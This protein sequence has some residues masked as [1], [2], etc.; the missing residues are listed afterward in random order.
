MT[1]RLVHP[2]LRRALAGVAFFAALVSARR[3]SAEDCPCTWEEVICRADAVAEVEMVFGTNTTPDRMVV[4]REIWNRTK[5]RVRSQ[6]GRP[7]IL[8]A[9]LT[10][11]E[12]LESVARYRREPNAHLDDEWY[13]RATRAL[14][15]GGY[16][17][18]I[19][20]RYRSPSP[21]QG[22]GI[23]YDGREWLDHPKHATWWAQVQPYLEQYIEAAKKNRKP[24]FCA[25]TSREATH[26]GPAPL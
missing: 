17:S 2:G 12:L 13:L 19:F 10:R 26:F 25:N 24:A 6:F 3:A 9:T 20:L 7:N 16:R 18:I 14:R 21:W 5:H 4:R 11:R 1:S 15:Q 23:A 22:G 8:Y